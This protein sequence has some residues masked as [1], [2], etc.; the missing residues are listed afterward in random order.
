[1]LNPMDSEAIFRKIAD[2][3]HDWESWIAPDGS[4]RWVNPAVMRVSGYSIGEC[5]AMPDYPQA[6]AHPDD[7]PSFQLFSE[8][9][10]K[11]LDGNNLAFRLKRK[12]GAVTWVAM[13]WQPFFGPDGEYLGVRLSIRDSS[14]K[15]PNCYLNQL[16]PAAS[17]AM[18]DAMNAVG[19]P[20][21]VYR[22]ITE[23]AARSLGVAR[24]GVWLLDKTG[25]KL[26]CANIFTLSENSHANGLSI[27][28]EKY[29]RYISAV[30][31]DQLV[32]ASDALNDPV[33]QE[34][35]SDYLKPLGILSMLD[36]PI[37]RGG[38]TIGVLCHEHTGHLRYWN[39]TELAFVESLSDFLTLSLE[40]AERIELEE[41]TRRL[42]SIIEAT[43]DAVITVTADG[44][45]LYMNRAAYQ[46]QVPRGDSHT[47]EFRT[48]NI[49]ESYSYD[50]L[51]FRNEVVVPAAMRDGHWSGE[52]RLR[53]LTGEE[54]PVW[55]TMIAHRDS[56][57][58]VKYLSSILHDLREQKRTEDLL[59]ASEQSLQV[60]NA[61]LETRIAERTQK[62]E[63]VNRN[64]EAFAYSV[65][66]DLKAPLR[67]IDGYARLLMEDYR[68]QLPGEAPQFVDN[69]CTAADRM[70]QLIDDLLAF[71]RVGRRE[72]SATHFA[73]RQ[74]L[75]RILAERQHDIDLRVVKIVNELGELEITADLD[76]FLQLLRNL[77]DNAIKFTRD[78]ERPTV[79][80]SAKQDDKR[81][82][83]TVK[84]NGCGFDMKYHDRIFSIFQRLHRIE[85]FPGTGIGLAI[86]GKSAE[87]MGGRVWAQSEPGRGA[88][89]FVELPV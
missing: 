54:I 36:V 41:Q 43:P 42:A 58:S 35:A 8:Y 21:R 46:A 78:T 89:F 37:M 73:L 88:E 6:M 5:M 12:D 85:D 84:D 48:A 74:V 33:T 60:L 3:T 22:L 24:V 72:L 2:A 83:V 86:V 18:R 38:K 56:E 40:S 82:L 67:G 79:I 44:T 51:K 80:V 65:A 70:H 31:R 7:L 50:A 81:T 61:G 15:L 27:R 66:H 53:A 34:L 23:C 1:M 68:A 9:V 63:E 59:R 47:A 28:V 64:L 30:M 55:Q 19:D 77:V 75:E 69:I 16:R 4:L 13:S 10:D 14:R 71:S 20:V 62:V 52:I 26:V 39:Q 87:R 49:A 76:C 11:R 32:I 45:P 57:G 29:P 25:Q 17:R